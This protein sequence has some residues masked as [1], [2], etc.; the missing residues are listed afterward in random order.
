M[1][2]GFDY[3][4]VIYSLVIRVFYKGTI[5]LSSFTFY[6]L[7]KPTKN[8]YY[9]LHKIARNNMHNPVIFKINLSIVENT[10]R[11]YLLPSNFI[12]TLRHF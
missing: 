6:C 11:L 12:P 8:A 10:A 1:D 2:Y 3:L 5:S 9:L 4:L 7:F